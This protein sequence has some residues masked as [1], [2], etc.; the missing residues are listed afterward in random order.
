MS[1]FK[2]PR[3]SSSSQLFSLFHPENLMATSE[4]GEWDTLDSGIRIPDTASPTPPHRRNHIS[5]ASATALDSILLG[6]KRS[7]RELKQVFRSR[8]CDGQCKMQRVY[9]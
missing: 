6:Q 3:V 5:S 9:Q 7:S 8:K 4:L 1:V 2:A